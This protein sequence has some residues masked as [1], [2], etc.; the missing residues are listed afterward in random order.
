MNLDG[1]TI[2]ITGAGG[3]I[4]RRMV[5]RCVERGFTVRGLDMSPGAAQFA[6]QAG[7]EMLVG[8]VCDPDTARQLCRGADV[9]F[10]TAAVVQEG[11]DPALFERVNIGGT[12]NMAAAA[13][14]MGVRRF[15][16]LSSVM[17]YGFDYPDDVTEDGPLRGEGNPYCQ[18]KIDSEQVALEFHDPAG[19]G[20]TIIR[21]G[22]VYGPRSMP[23]TVRPIELMRRR[24]F[25][26]PNGGRGLLSHV[27]VDNLLDAVLLA[28]ERDATGEALN[29]TDGRRTTFREFFGY[30]E[31]MLGGRRVFTMP[32]GLL[33]LGV[34]LQCRISRRLGRPPLA[35]PD[36]IP[37]YARRGSYSIEKA[38][39][40]LGYEPRVSLEE[41]M[42]NIERWLGESPQHER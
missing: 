29:I 41:G 18:T 33:R 17:V 6:E 26:I 8:D 40:Q 19:M 12:R 7:A 34:R 24:M 21:A 22:D 32:A 36:F 16:Q 27:Y 13:A 14:E 20:V 35:T 1:K 25:I 30:Y 3:F 42:R 11:G 2:A 9:V 28:L 4:G 15:V 31:R 5:E 10:H 23:W 39:R 38:R 37:F